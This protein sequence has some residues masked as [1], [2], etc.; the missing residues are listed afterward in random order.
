MADKP[1]QRVQAIFEK[2]CA[3]PADHLEAFLLEACG[4]DAAVLREVRSLLNHRA[5]LPADFLVT[6]PRATLAQGPT[7]SQGAGSLSLE[8]V[9][10]TLSA[11][12]AARD[13]KIPIIGGYEVIRAL[14][15]GGQGVV[16]EAIQRS[17][18][19]KVALKV[20]HIARYSSNAAMKRFE[21]EIE[22]IAQFRHPNIISVFDSGTTGDQEPYYVMDYVRGMPLDRHCKSNELTL[23]DTL[24]LFGVLCDAVQYAHQRGVIHRDLKPSNILVDSDGAPK[25]MDFG[26]AKLMAGSVETEVSRSQEI[27]GTLPYLSPEQARGNPD[28]IDTRTD[29]YALGV[30][31]YRLLTGHF[32]YPVDGEMIAV[33]K[34]IVDMPPTPLQRQWTPESGIK[35]RS[36]GK[37]RVGACPIDDEVQTI[38]LRALAKERTRRYQT[39]GDLARDVALYLRHEPIEAKSDSG[40]YV[41]RKSLR[42]QRVP[43]T[44]AG[45]VVLCIASLG[46]GLAARYKTV[47]A[48]DRQRAVESDQ[49]VTFAHADRLLTVYRYGKNQGIPNSLF[50]PPAQKDMVDTAAMIRRALRREPHYFPLPVPSGDADRQFFEL[51]YDSLYSRSAN[52]KLSPNNAIVDVARLPQP[53]AN[54]RV[55]VFPIRS[56][57]SWHDGT[58]LTAADVLFSLELRRRLLPEESLGLKATATP[59]GDV[60]FEFEGVRDC[61]MRMCN[62]PIIPKHIF[63]SIATTQP[64]RSQLRLALE[65]AARRSHIGTG[66]YALAYI[67]NPGEPIELQRWDRYLG[68]RPLFQRVQFR[69][70]PDRTAALDEFRNGQLD[71]LELTDAQASSLSWK[72]A[73]EPY[74]SIVTFPTDAYVALMFNWNRRPELF[75]DRRVRRALALAFNMQKAFASVGLG[76]DDRVLSIF[77][78]VSGVPRASASDQPGFDPQEALRLLADA[79]WKMDGGLLRKPNSGNEELLRLEILVP[80]N[81]M[82]TIAV[83]ES[84]AKDLQQ[85][86]ISASLARV[87]EDEWSA[88][89]QAGDFDSTISTILPGLEPTLDDKIWTSGKSDRTLPA[90]WMP[91]DEVVHRMFEDAKATDDADRRLRILQAIQNRVLGEQLAMPLFRFDRKWAIAKSICGIQIGIRGP[92]DFS[93]GFRQWWVTRNVVSQ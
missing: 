75:G 60:R 62:C 32:P 77:S 57:V 13:G 64:E 21:R 37:W 67:G 17:T 93:P 46:W 2:A 47:A 45:L 11:P 49:E 10:I 25:L 19:R 48:H 28:E 23:E 56:G 88:R 9:K 12:E 39:A 35:R 30:M 8:S 73:L 1:F 51:L 81:A 65:A 89:V 71:V 54:E 42:R 61:A 50:A 43:L 29:V 22:L 7:V 84:L 40:W 72:Q 79:G 27:V 6:P 90:N 66:P 44:F 92:F 58:P 70:R 87:K 31:L 5:N 74:G 69:I 18:K 36:S 34:R 76:P 33:L 86:G 55:L 26:L 52:G 80:E 38:V 41:L 16:Y 68:E 78:Q 59:G 24:R 63:E 20:L 83:L 91:T 3:V 85:L 53:S 14:G 4:D 15:H 82:T